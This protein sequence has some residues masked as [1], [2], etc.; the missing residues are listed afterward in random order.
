MTIIFHRMGFASLNKNPAWGSLYRAR[1]KL[2]APHF[3][4]L[5]IFVL[6]LLESWLNKN[7]MVAQYNCCMQPRVL[8]SDFGFEAKRMALS[9]LATYTYIYSL[10]QAAEIADK[11]RML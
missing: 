1:W 8:F 7:G 3:P 2:I 4:S 11:D 10:P 9:C 5:G 6:I